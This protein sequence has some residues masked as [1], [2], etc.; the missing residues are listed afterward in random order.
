M[1]NRVLK[2]VLLSSVIFA[3]TSGLKLAALESKKPVEKSE[4]AE[5]SSKKQ[6]RPKMDLAFCIDTTGSMQGE[7]DLVK[8][9]VRDLVAKLCAGKPAPI[10][11]VGLVAFR[12]TT[13]DYVTK[14]YDFTDDIDKFVKDISALQAQGG[15]DAPEA[16]DTAIRTAVEKLKWDESKKTAKLLFLIGDAGPHSSIPLSTW[17]GTC[18]RAIANGIQI[19]TIGCEGLEQFSEKDGAGFFKQVAKLTDGRF[20]T[21][22]YRQVVTNSDGSEKTLLRS[23]GRS[24]EVSSG[25]KDEWKKGASALAGA[26]KAKA[27]VPSGARFYR[28]RGSIEGTSAAGF[29]PPV[30]DRRESNLDSIMFGAAL[31]KSKE[32]LNVE[33]K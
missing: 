33:Y 19:N 7:I 5:E 22:A 20:E 6:T 29:A 26:G 32:T 28:T 4:A 10:V 1:N 21:L 14:V 18:H 31:K 27:I 2:V 9:K 17:E 15:G 25:A 16:V 23:G 8:D 24:Y 3:G 12:D 11:R 30:V 13:D